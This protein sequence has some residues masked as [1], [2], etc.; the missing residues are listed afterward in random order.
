MVFATT[1]I[2]IVSF[3]DWLFAPVAFSCVYHLRLWPVRQRNLYQL[4]LAFCCFICNIWKVHGYLQIVGNKKGRLSDL[5]FFVLL[6][7]V[8]CQHIYIKPAN[9]QRVSLMLN[10]TV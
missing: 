2:A 1:G 8:H 9:L 6:N 4:L 3:T 5:F 7:P 10:K